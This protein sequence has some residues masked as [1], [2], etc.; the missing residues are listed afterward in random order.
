MNRCDYPMALRDAKGGFQMFS[1]SNSNA[2]VREYKKRRKHE[3][4]NSGCLACRI[5]RVKVCIKL[6]SG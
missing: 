6:E 5:K 4:A 2:E 3:K 1:Q